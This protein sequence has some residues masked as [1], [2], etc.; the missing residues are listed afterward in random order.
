MKWLSRLASS[1]SN[2]RSLRKSG[3]KIV[4]RPLEHLEHRALGT[5]DA[6]EAPW[7][8]GKGVAEL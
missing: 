5:L 6:N 3:A 2:S 4:F 1:D 7:Y 8:R